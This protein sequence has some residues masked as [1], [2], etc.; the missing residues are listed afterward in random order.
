MNEY[1]MVVE[2]LPVQLREDW[3]RLCVELE[4]KLAELVNTIYITPAY[5]S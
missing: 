5:T 3:I 2:I 1:A 4:Q